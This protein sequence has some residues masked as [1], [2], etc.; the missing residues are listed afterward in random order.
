M[1]APE[2]LTLIAGITEGVLGFVFEISHDVYKSSER[3]KRAREEFEAAFL[4]AY[5]RLAIDLP[6]YSGALL[7]LHF[8]QGEE[9]Q[10]EL[11]KILR[12]EHGPS[13]QRINELWKGQG[14]IAENADASP[15]ISH[16]IVVLLNELR[17]KES[18][19]SLLQRKDIMAIAESA[20]AVAR[21]QKRMLDVVE[22]EKQ[23]ALDASFD[24]IESVL[25]RS[26][27]KSFLFD[28][29]NVFGPSWHD[30][31]QGNVFKRPEVDELLA[32]LDSES[33]AVLLG[34]VFS[35]KTV[36][37]RYCAFLLANRGTNVFLS[38]SRISLEEAKKLIT[39][40]Q[41][42]DA[43]FVFDDIHDDI[44]LFLE[45]AQ[46]LKDGGQPRVKFL[47][48]GRTY[49]KTLVPE[50]KLDFR[51]F[52]APIILER[53]REL[54]PSYL[55]FVGKKCDYSFSEHEKR[56]ASSEY[57]SNFKY[58]NLALSLWLDGGKSESIVRYSQAATSM[59]YFNLLIERR[60]AKLSPDAKKLYW[61][62]LGLSYFGISAPYSWVERY[63]SGKKLSFESLASLENSGLLLSWLLKKNS[64]IQHKFLYAGE[65]FYSELI[66]K[67][68]Y[69]K[70]ILPHKIKQIAED[71][72]RC[73][74]AGPFNPGLAAVFQ[75]IS[76]PKHMVITRRLFD[77]Q[78]ILKRITS[79]IA[80]MDPAPMLR[81]L[82][83][84]AFCDK[85]AAKTVTIELDWD[86]FFDKLVQD[87][88]VSLHLI[89]QALHVL[90]VIEPSKLAVKFAAKLTMH[91]YLV[92][93][94][95]SGTRSFFELAWFAIYLARVDFREAD[96]IIPHLK[97]KLFL[98]NGR[99]VKDLE[100]LGSVGVYELALLLFGIYLIDPR[101]AREALAA[102]DEHKLR[103]KFE[104]RLKAGKFQLVLGYLYRV[105]PRFTI[106]MLNALDVDT[107]IEE[108]L[109]K[110]TL[111][112]FL[113]G[114]RKIAD[115]HPYL[116]AMIVA[117]IAPIVLL[118]KW[119]QELTLRASGL[120]LRLLRSINARRAKDF[121]NRLP[122]QQLAE[123]VI[124]TPYA[125]QA[126]H[127]LQSLRQA[128]PAF[129]AIVLSLISLDKL[130][131]KLPDQNRKLTSMA[132][133]V[134]SVAEIDKSKGS[135]LM[136]FWNEAFQREYQSE[137]LSF[138]DLGSGTLHLASVFP[139]Y[140]GVLLEDSQ[141][142]LK[143]IATGDP[144]VREITFF[145]SGVRK[146]CKLGSGTSLPTY[147]LERKEW[148]IA[149]VDG[150]GKLDEIGRY[151]QVL[152]DI[153]TEMADELA[154]N[155]A[156]WEA[157]LLR[158][159]RVHALGEISDLILGIARAS[160]LSRG[161]SGEAK[162][163]SVGAKIFGELLKEFAER[164]HS[165]QRM[166]LLFKFFNSVAKSTQEFPE[167]L[168]SF[169]AAIGDAKVLADKI[170]GTST[171]HFVTMYLASIRRLSPSLAKEVLSLANVKFLTALFNAEH[172]IWRAT[173][174]INAIYAIDPVFAK[175]FLESTLD[176]WHFG[177]R[178]YA[179]N[180]PRV[181]AE[182]IVRSYLTSPAVAKDLAKTL[183]K[184]FGK[185]G[186]PEKVW[187]SP[188]EEI[189][190]LLIALMMAD[191]VSGKQFFEDY[192]NNEMYF[193][194]IEILKSHDFDPKW[195]ILLTAILGLVSK[196]KSKGILRILLGHLDTPSKME[197]ID[198]FALFTLNKKIHP[199]LIVPAHHR[200]LSGAEGDFLFEEIR[201]S[202]SLM[203]VAFI[204]AAGASYSEQVYIAVRNRILEEV[205]RNGGKVEC[206]EARMLSVLFEKNELVFS[207]EDSLF[208]GSEYFKF[209]AINDPRFYW[210]LARK[211][212]DH[213]IGWLTLDE[214]A[215]FDNPDATFSYSDQF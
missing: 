166:S 81:T 140:V 109:S 182:F 194:Y 168:E 41:E 110:L 212:W 31:E 163:L 134:R 103:S 62:L 192:I 184:K 196:E 148:Y 183:T 74:I 65:A 73:F 69:R 173:W 82:D 147:I 77:S 14:Q 111:L 3:H 1:L 45:L 164:V 191:R 106:E 53:P 61:L 119:N 135:E 27:G 133:L 42:Q 118:E 17:T 46:V 143:R 32:R 24:P 156:L 107:L 38:K 63:L 120:S 97:S 117:K 67:S 207:E 138:Q 12:F 160:I 86:I 44:E 121:L 95:V 72:L 213:K 57:G 215:Q 125:N 130:L 124:S 8:F 70:G 59:R 87:G 187:L 52:M 13:I 214:E 201:D 169:V 66:L 16:F 186:L 21:T 179:E 68:A 178:M 54:V 122:P 123:R 137:N 34:P 4:A 189:A 75:K 105:D 29:Q 128:H 51:D 195:A 174:F 158:A 112:E 177:Q 113:Q 18:L 19:S 71:S 165:E 50:D 89:G 36:L 150:E 188:I 151:V 91:D 99:L 60:L 144:N 200:Y 43:L 142:A 40:Y 55:E 139:E 161:S 25:R 49:E 85:R 80:R 203:D 126:G 79:H 136:R 146:A 114:I 162:E 37:A 153:S 155:E 76:Q 197:V 83:A 7:D 171:L 33:F 48:V 175:A 92:R 78:K 5:E 115:L 20:S 101:L 176:L 30:F 88:D 96:K 154:L 170:A 84:L 181:L 9:V 172:F 199:E 98:Q 47:F 116:G 141:E 108:N 132:I 157:I 204:F 90:H 39:A 56:F 190:C 93:R 152:A 180:R 102:V 202:K 206:L 127:F 198:W 131:E 145:L 149:R 167:L 2:L 104:Y 10:K 129:A 211:W 26:L 6:E 58:F 28:P 100:I 94:L 159:K 35:G 185:D 209:Q 11:A 210:L 193:M 205:E 22:T 208:S 23:E 64:D 15:A